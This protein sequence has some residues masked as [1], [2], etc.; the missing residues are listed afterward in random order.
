MVATIKKKR[1]APLKA[2]IKFGPNHADVLIEKLSEGETKESLIER[3]NRKMAE[4][5]DLEN[6]IRAKKRVKR[7]NESEANQPNRNR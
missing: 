4:I 7:N 6:E 3:A 2:R 5:T 1:V